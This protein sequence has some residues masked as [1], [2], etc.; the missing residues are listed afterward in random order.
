MRVEFLSDGKDQPQI[1]VQNCMYALTFA[2]LLS[3][4]LVLCMPFVTGKQVA[5]KEGTC[6]LE[7]PEM[8]EEDSKI[9][10]YAITAMRYLILLG[11]YGGLAGVI[12]GINIYLPPGA[13][14]L[15]KLPP[16]APAVMCTMILASFFFA[17]QLVIAV[18]RSYGEYSG[19]EFP[20]TTG[21]MNAAATTVEFAPMLAILFLSA[22]MRALQHDG[23]PQKWAQDCMYAATY[24][25]CVTTLLAIVVPLVLGGTMKTNPKTRE[26]TFD[27]PNPTIGYAMVA[28][29]YICMLGF[30]GG[31]VGVAYSI[32]VFEAP[33]GPEATLPVSPTVH[34]V[35]NLTSQ[36]FF[37]YFMM[38]VML[39]VSEF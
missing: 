33:A 32:F 2:V 36:F 19:V 14:D 34:C 38:T 30:Y 9:A 4:I 24:S 18:C 29:R 27:M 26:T 11:L 16:P 15:N 1:W 22:R 5:M 17:I 12:V 37:V 8:G 21:I 10:F 35:V 3:T 23:Q 6:D 28:V 13:T 39:T 25:M 20:K 7:M 31:A